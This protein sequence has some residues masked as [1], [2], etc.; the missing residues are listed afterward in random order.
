MLFTSCHLR[1]GA[2]IGL[3]AA[4]CAADP[5]AVAAARN[6][7]Q[8]W[9]AVLRTRRVLRAATE[10]LCPGARRAI[11]LAERAVASGDPCY[12][13]GELLG[14]GGERVTP[15]ADLS[16]LPSGSRV[17]FPAHGVTL[18][19]AAEAAAR[20][21]RVTDATCPLVAT[22]QRAVRGYAADGDTVVIVAGPYGHAVRDGLAGQ[23]PE[24]AAFAE[25]ETDLDALDIA[26][27]VSFVLQPG[28]PVE[29]LTPVAAALRARH[30]AR[31]ASP[32]GWC[33]WASDRLATLRAV[34]AES[35]LMLV[36]GAPGVLWDTCPSYAY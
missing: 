25:A 12:A 22:A 14:Y 34:A 21:L 19:V 24:H 26:G 36:L 6:V 29:Q 20:G 9:T 28:V 15:V 35:Q 16:A 30:S 31:G 23:A 27:Q 5:V 11:A 2:A 3:G 13:H 8:A 1:D 33:Y 7:V 18:A 10:P 32:D 4:A 17:V